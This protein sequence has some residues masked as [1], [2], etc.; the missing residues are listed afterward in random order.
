MEIK[1]IHTNG[2]ILLV[3]STS[4]IDYNKNFLSKFD[5]I[6]SFDLETHRVLRSNSIDHKI[7]EDFFSDNELLSIDK[8]KIHFK[9]ISVNVAPLNN[10]D[11]KDISAFLPVI[12]SVTLFLP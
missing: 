8:S 6:I 5:E 1:N 9:N 2:K 7:S 3:D 4:I 10:F 11:F 12:L